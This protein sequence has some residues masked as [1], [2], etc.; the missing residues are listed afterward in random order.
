MTELWYAVGHPSIAVEKLA[1]LLCRRTEVHMP[2]NFCITRSELVSFQVSNSAT[3]LDLTL[4]DLHFFSDNFKLWSFH[5]LNNFS[6]WV[7]SWFS[8][9]ACRIILSSHGSYKLCISWKYF[10]TCAWKWLTALFSSCE[11]LVDVNIPC[12]AI[13]PHASRGSLCNVICQ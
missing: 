9:L 2:S 13:I 4:K 1:R 6:M 12:V 11:T 3:P 5:V 8:F 7:I 10:G